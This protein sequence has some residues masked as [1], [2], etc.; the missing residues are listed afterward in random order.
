MRANHRPEKGQGNLYAMY[1]SLGTYHV[2]VNSVT[3]EPETPREQE[4]GVADIIELDQDEENE[5]PITNTSE[6][7]N[8]NTIMVNK[9]P[10][11]RACSPFKVI[12]VQTE[13]GIF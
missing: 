7:A 1:N 12:Q 11:G 6:E 9:I 10:V 8:V 5:D 2:Q 13:N 3:M 4:F